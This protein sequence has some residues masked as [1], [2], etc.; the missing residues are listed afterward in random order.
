MTSRQEKRL[1]RLLKQRDEQAFLTVVTRYQHKV[2]NLVYR[3]LGDPHEAED[4]AQEVFITVLKNI[5]SF[6]GDSKFST[7][8]FRIA[9]NHSKNRIKYLKRRA[10]DRTQGLD[11][12]PESA[13]VYS[14][15][16][17]VLPRPD[18]QAMG[19]QLEKVMQRALASLEPEHRE[20]VVLRDIEN[21][22]YQEIQ[23]ITGLGLG[24]V[25]SRLHRARVAL[26]REVSQQYDD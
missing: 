15:F 14:P 2:Y 10:S 19:H 4:V 6:R 5:G 16:G 13:M 21:L 9:V 24:T 12:V 20:I 18:T 23:E 17:A 11:D 26:K 22:S 1:I 7:W 25:K 8:L 3:M